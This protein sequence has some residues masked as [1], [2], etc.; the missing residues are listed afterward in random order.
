MPWN[1]TLTQL[2]S[3]LAELYP[4]DDDVHRLANQAGLP[5][6]YIDFDG[7]AIQVW[8]NLL[9]QAQQRD[10][11]QSLIEIVN[12]EYPENQPLAQAIQAYD[13]QAAALATSHPEEGQPPN[14]GA[15]FLSSLKIPHLG[16]SV[17]VAISLVAMVLVGGLAYALASWGLPN[18]QATATATL[19]PTPTSTDTPT[20][21]WT[22]EPTQTPTSTPTATITLTPSPTPWPQP[23]LVTSYV[24]NL[25]YLT[26]LD[27][28]RYE[29]GF[30]PS[31]VI[32][33]F[34]QLD[35]LEWVY[36]N[37]NQPDEAPAFD[38]TLKLNNVG[39][40][41]ILL[42]LSERFFSLEDDLGN[43]AEMVYFCCAVHG[44]SLAPGK[45][46]LIRLVFNFSPGW[47]TKSEHQR[48]IYLWVRGLRPI[49]SARWWIA[50]PGVAD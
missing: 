5:P 18:T 8:H 16:P 33:G 9:E 25:E 27:E 47:L 23:N 42:D 45:A 48:M 34:L 2:Q 7:P 39:Q 38:L 32:T 4:L 46:R 31:Q 29:E 10:R 26:G 36:I 44:A 6:A 11:L 30:F 37:P 17:Q 35:Q 28:Y 24:Y 49:I 19:P 20:F 41:P 1:P 40:A 12:H 15:S 50:L 3:V 43:Q 21:T 13:P 22:P 14:K